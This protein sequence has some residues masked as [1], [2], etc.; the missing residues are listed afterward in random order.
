MKA[1]LSAMACVLL[2]TIACHANQGHSAT[3]Y[4]STS[5]T[6]VRDSSV[7]DS[8]MAIE[9]SALQMGRNYQVISFNKGSDQLTEMEKNSLRSLM[10]TAKLAGA[11]DRVH[12]IGWSD[13]AFPMGRTAA[14]LPKVDRDLAKARIDK[15][16]DFL[17]SQLDISGVKTYSM[18]EKANWFARAF[19]TDEA[20]LKSM[21]SQ[22]GDVDVKPEEFKMIKDKGGP[23]KAVILVQHKDGAAAATRS[24]H[25]PERI[26]TGTS[27]SEQDLD[28]E[29]GMTTDA[30]IES[31]A[32]RSVRE[33]APAEKYYQDEFNIQ[34]P[35]NGD[36]MVPNL[37]NIQATGG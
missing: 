21:F 30:D 2:A 1:N 7:S 26:S 19:N 33:S 4:D 5:G 28:S 36:A 11:I 10:E 13:K 17:E 20:E 32:S 14:D 31:G 9:S 37:H 8:T 3:T 34:H 12:V 23:M 6:S 35:N 29:S 24:I 27:S 15:I 22:K 18:A 16:E 25:K